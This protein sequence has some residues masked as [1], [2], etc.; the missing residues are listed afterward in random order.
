MLIFNIKHNCASYILQ[1]G[2]DKKIIMYANREIGKGE[3]ITY[4]YQFDLEAEKLKCTCGS[5]NCQG[6]LN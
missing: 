2:E 3:E 4:D 6:R 1:I 5:K